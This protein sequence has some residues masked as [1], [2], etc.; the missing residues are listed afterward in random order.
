MAVVL[1]DD[2]RSVPFTPGPWNSGRQD[3]VTLSGDSEAPWSKSVYAPESIGGYLVAE[4][5]SP[6]QNTALANARLVAAAPKLYETLE[7]VT[8]WLEEQGMRWEAID[9]CRAALTIATE[10]GAS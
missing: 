5:H 8:A 3:T 9:E 6:D 1:L 2:P 4:A 10:G 7:K